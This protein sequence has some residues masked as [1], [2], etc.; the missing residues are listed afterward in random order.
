MFSFF[1]RALSLAAVISR[2]L[3]PFGA[4]SFILSFAPWQHC[5]GDFIL[6]DRKLNSRNTLYRRLFSAMQIH[7]A[8]GKINIFN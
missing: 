3:V 5:G 7:F 1:P 4:S 2:T 6:R 8:R